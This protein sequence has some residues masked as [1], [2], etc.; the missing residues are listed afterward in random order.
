VATVSDLGEQ[1]GGV[2]AIETGQGFPPEQGSW[3]GLQGGERSV[4]VAGGHGDTVASAVLGELTGEVIA[5]QEG[6]VADR[7][8]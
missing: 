7:Y 3:P 5:V 2:R 1:L 6:A 8:N 4:P